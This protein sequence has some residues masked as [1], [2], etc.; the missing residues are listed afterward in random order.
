VTGAVDV[1]KFH[2]FHVELEHRHPDDVLEE[3]VCGCDGLQFQICPVTV[4]GEAQGRFPLYAMH[5]E[6]KMSRVGKRMGVFVRADSQGHLAMAQCLERV[7]ELPDSVMDALLHEVRRG[8]AG[9]SGYPDGLEEA[10]QARHNNFV[11]HR[12]HPY[13]YQ[14]GT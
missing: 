6:Q 14:P 2:K 3:A 1:I 9:D 5:R 13:T 7:V 10:L 4:A 11:T 8:L 12:H